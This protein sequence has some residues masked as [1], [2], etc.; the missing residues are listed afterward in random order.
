MIEILGLE[1]G[2]HEF[3]VFDQYISEFEHNDHSIAAQ[4]YKDTLAGVDHYEE[5]RDLAEAIRLMNFNFDEQTTLMGVPVKV[6]GETYLA[7]MRKIYDEMRYCSY[8][9]IQKMA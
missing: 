1:A 7:I 6:D 5:N 4:I 3:I 8:Q 9:E 2:S